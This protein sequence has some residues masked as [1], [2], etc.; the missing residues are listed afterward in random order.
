MKGICYLRRIVE[1]SVAI[2]VYVCA[3]L[4]LQVIKLSVGVQS[5]IST[6]LNSKHG[7]WR[8]A[9]SQTGAAAIVP[10]IQTRRV[11]L[12]FHIV[13]IQRHI[14]TENSPNLLVHDLLHFPT[15]E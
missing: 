15:V 2:C 7:C 14:L 6:I 9:A 10:C 8:S 4:K 3:V 12:I 13:I 11:V 5:A 1:L